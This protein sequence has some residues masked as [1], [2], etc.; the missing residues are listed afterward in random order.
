[1]LLMQY[2]AGQQEQGHATKTCVMSSEAIRAASE[3]GAGCRGTAAAGKGPEEGTLKVR[4][5]SGRTAVGW[6]RLL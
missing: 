6:S 2:A 1:M 5:S 3:S 4:L